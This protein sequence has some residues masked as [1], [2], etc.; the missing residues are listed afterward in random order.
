MVVYNL[1]CGKH[2]S[3]EGWFAS[4]ES[5][6]AQHRQG[7]LTCPMCESQDITRRPAGSYVNV[8]STQ[9]NEQHAVALTPQAAERVR[10]KMADFIRRHTED[11]GYDFPEEA[12]KIFYKEAAPRNIRGVASADEVSDMRDE[13]IELLPLPPG[14]L[15]PD[16]LQ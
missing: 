3:F 11:V 12:R 2:H 13:G 4:P 16:K 8:K 6:D 15:P 9:S 14:L 7:G 1:V 10:A 5:Y